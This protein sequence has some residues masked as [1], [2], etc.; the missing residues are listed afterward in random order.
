MTKRMKQ[1]NIPIKMQR[2]GGRTTKATTN[3]KMNNDFIVIKI[4]FILAVQ[5]IIK[6][7]LFCISNYK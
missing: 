5:M 4:V 7:I 6:C 1:L 2:G 3:N